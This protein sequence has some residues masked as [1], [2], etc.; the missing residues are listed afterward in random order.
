MHKNLK[1]LIDF[2]NWCEDELSLGKYH[3]P[4]DLKMIFEMIDDSARI[5]NQHDGD[6]YLD[7]EE[8]FIDIYQQYFEM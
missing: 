2:T 5:Y 8:K 6:L 1:L 4:H 3:N 7:T